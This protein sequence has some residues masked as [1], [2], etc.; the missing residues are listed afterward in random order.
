MAKFPTYA[1]SSQKTR[2]WPLLI[3][4]ALLLLCV[5]GASGCASVSPLVIKPQQPQLRPPPPEL[6]VPV[7]PNFRKR[8][9]SL[10]TVSSPKL[11]QLQEN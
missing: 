5:M 2:P 8:L 9:E 10:F 1:P 7:Q 6:M 3:M 4:I 11:T